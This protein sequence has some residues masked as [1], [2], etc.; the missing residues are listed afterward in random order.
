MP[1]RDFVGLDKPER[2]STV[3]EKNLIGKKGIGT[4]LGW[5]GFL[6][7]PICLI[8]TLQYFYLL[9][10]EPVCEYLEAQKLCLLCFILLFEKGSLSESGAHKLA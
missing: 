8:V 3:F 2:T 10:V 6:M 1:W 4:A 7:D 9:R 5:E